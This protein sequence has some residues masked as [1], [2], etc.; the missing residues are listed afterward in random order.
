M[1]LLISIENV[2][3]ADATFL[4]LTGKA[5]S[6]GSILFRPG[7]GKP[8]AWEKP[9]HPGAGC[10]SSGQTPRPPGGHCENCSQ[11]PWFGGEPVSPHNPDDDKRHRLDGQSAR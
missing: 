1:L 2:P 7:L 6:L 3:Y 10:L 5:P 8:L 11:S 4:F 9:C